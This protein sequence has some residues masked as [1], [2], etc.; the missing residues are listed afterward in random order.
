MRE[1][2]MSMT[3]PTGFV[4]PPPLVDTT[5]S[6]VAGSPN[7]ATGVRRSAPSPSG[8]GHGERVNILGSGAWPGRQ[9]GGNHLCQGCP[10]VPA[11][12]DVHLVLDNYATHKA[13]VVK[14]WL[15][16]RPRFHLHFTPT[17]GSWLN[18]VERWFGLL[19]QRAIKRGAHLSTKEL[20]AAIM[21]YLAS[22]N[23]EDAKPFVWTKTA[24]D[25]L[26]RIARFAARTHSA[27]AAT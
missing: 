8:R 10:L 27:H 15:E 3:D 5:S 14:R 24:D 12:L 26:A 11:D 7:H 22:H 9:R 17:S 18:G 6:R 21:T 23:A 19:T 16:K 25:I 4:L 1:L 2:D 13:P 20:E